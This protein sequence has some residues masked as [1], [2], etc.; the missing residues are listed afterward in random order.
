M[1]TYRGINPDYRRIGAAVRRRR[2]ILG[3]Q[4]RHLVT[5]ARSTLPMALLLRFLPAGRVFTDG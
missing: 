4:A 2:R 3:P 1:E 5:N